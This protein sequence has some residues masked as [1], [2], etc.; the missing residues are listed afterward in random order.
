MLAAYDWGPANLDKD[1]AAHGSDWKK[2]LPNETAA[3]VPNAEAAIKAQIASHASTA[4][5]VEAARPKI[6]GA[7]IF[8]QAAAKSQQPPGHSLV[9]ELKLLRKKLT[10][11]T[12][13]SPANITVTNN[14]AGM[15]HIS[16]NAASGP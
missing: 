7:N 12:S 14:T 15:V 13:A 6:P 9:D 16:A 5:A 10:Q 11:K 3:Y 1:I 8:Q 2:Y 4:K